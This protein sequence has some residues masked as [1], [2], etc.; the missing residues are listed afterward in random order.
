MQPEMHD[1]VID[2]AAEWLVRLRDPACT[3]G[4]RE[5]FARWVGR[6]DAHRV[7][8]ERAERAWQ[9]IGSLEAEVPGLAESRARLAAHRAHAT[10]ARQRTTF[11][12]AMAWWKTPALAATA[13]IVAYVGYA[14]FAE[15]V[16]TQQAAYATAAGEGR[17]VQLEDGSRIEL[18][19]STRVQV[20]MY[21]A[22]REIVLEGGEAWFAVAHDASRP[23]RVDAGELKVE[24]TG[25]RF[26]VRRLDR[27]TSVA[28]EEGSV[29]VARAG[30]PD[31]ALPLAAG[32]GVSAP[33]AGAAMQVARV[34]IE[35]QT[36][37]RR[38]RLV[39]SAR[40]LGEVA[41]ELS[42]YRDAPILVA[43][44]V[45]SLPV[46]AVINIRAASEWLAVL[47][48]TLPVQVHPTTNGGLEVVAS[49]PVEAPA[50]GLSPVRVLSQ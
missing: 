19:T 1:T 18:N 46:T 4:T 25:T 7:E 20:K 12:G 26:A 33:A 15:N 35:Q 36:A 41:I 14:W 21:R 6:D 29:K 34:D 10:S 8:F 45:A 2:E 50:A 47:P 17:Q 31:H 32:Y 48:R 3:A 37:W 23:F 5:A 9:D 43:P 49:A 44:D 28:V 24:V 39:F 16:P 38:G 30:S 27:D 22:R 11:P 40:P 13:A 42:R